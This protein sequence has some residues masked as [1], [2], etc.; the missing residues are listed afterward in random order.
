MIAA[1]SCGVDGQTGASDTA[2]VVSRGSGAV[3]GKDGGYN[4]QMRGLMLLVAAI[5]L[6][7]TV[8]FAVLSPLLP[9]YA[10]SL[11]LSKSAVGIL[12]G[13]FA[14]G[15]LVAALP[16]GLLASRFGL[17][18]TLLLGLG[19]TGITCVIFGLS[20]TWSL[21]VLT[22][23]AAGLGSAC[24]WTAAVGWLARTA[25]PE[26]RGELIGFAIS[27]AVAGAFLGPALGAVAAWIGTGPAFGLIAVACTVLALRVMTLPEPD[28]ESRSV[29][30]VTALGMP[31]LWAPLGLIWLAPLLFA[32]LGVLVPL[33]LAARG[34]TAGQL[35][36]LYAGSAALEALVHPVLGRWA[37]RQGALAP[38]ST[39]LVAATAVLVGLAAAGSAWLVAGLVV[40]AAITFGATLVP[41]MALLT[42][43]AEA[44]GLDAVLA[45]ALA[46]LA[47]ALGH[48]VGSPV[49]G[50]LADR[51][52]DTLTY[53]MFA[54][55]CLAVL[56][57]LRRRRGMLIPSSP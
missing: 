39:G 8:F 23:F 55:L 35:G 43:T 6:V 41:G 38:I 50:W 19:L 7:D 49:C 42:R 3:N 17:R 2:P 25:P 47:W 1:A 14:A 13:A 22:R 45:M 18:P 44:A 36:A 12:A 28:A 5:V 30:M 54:G 32:V 46:N 40:A 20:T 10:A 29:T 31:S 53:M 33:S 26:R 37:D 27:A 9:S 11:G 16:S 4:G 51:V 24:S 56:V 15:V 52:G 48:A 57:V 21:L 34:W